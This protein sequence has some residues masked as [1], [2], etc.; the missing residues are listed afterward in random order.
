MGA[1]SAKFTNPMQPNNQYLYT[2]ESDSWIKV[3]TTG[4]AAAADTAG[5]MFVKAGM[6]IPLMNP[7][8]SGT[9]NAFVHA[10]RQ[11][12]DGDATLTLIGYR[13]V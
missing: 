12:T 3:T 1:A 10:I 8:D 7:D 13:Y 9:T 4:G 11:T 6:M 5:N 2:C